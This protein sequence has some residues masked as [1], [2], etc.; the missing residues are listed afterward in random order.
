[1]DRQQEVFIFSKCSE[2]CLKNVKSGSPLNVSTTSCGTNVAA[3]NSC[4]GPLETSRIKKCILW[5]VRNERLHSCI[6]GR[7]EALH[8]LKLKALNAMMNFS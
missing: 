6:E 5:V 1:M 8:S 4:G 7:A 3:T 2:H